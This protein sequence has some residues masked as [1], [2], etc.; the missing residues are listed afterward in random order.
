MMI[1]LCSSLL[2]LN[3]AVVPL[4]RALP[5]MRTAPLEC[6]LDDG[7]LLDVVL[8][9]RN[10][11][12]CRQM[13]QDN[14]KCIFYH[15]YQG[16]TNDRALDGAEDVENQPAQCF[17]YD[18]CNREV[19]PATEDC[20]LTKANAV[21]VE[22]FVRNADECKKSC[23]NNVDCGYFKYFEAGD[24]KQPLFCYHLKKCAPRVIRRAECPLERN[25]Y[26][27]HFLF[28]PTQ[29]DCRQK[30]QDHTECR[31]WYWYPID[32]SPAPLYCYLYRSCEGGADEQTIGM[33]IGGRHPGFYFLDEAETSDLVKGGAVCPKHVESNVTSIGRGG[34]VAEFVE[35]SVLLCG[36]R[37]KQNRVLGNCMAYNPMSNHWDSHS[38]LIDMREE[39]SSVTV[40]GQMYIMGG[41]VNGEMVRTSEKLSGDTWT[42][43]PSLPEGR[44]RFCAVT[45]DDSSIAILGGEVP[46]SDG[47]AISAEM[48]TYNIDNGDWTSQPDMLVRRKDH[49]C[50]LVKIDEEI[51]LLVSGGVDGEDNLLDSV[52]FYNLETQEWQELSPLKKART[53]HG[54]EV[55]GGLVTVLGGV[56]NTEFLSSVEVLDNS[57]DSDAPLGFEWR[58]TAHALTAPRYDFALAVAPV[59]SLSLEDRGM[60]DCSSN[61]EIIES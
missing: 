2:L 28:V 15:F 9:A 13:C 25:N 44:S 39:A 24:A 33:V 17:L 20:P 19:L 56:S 29:T 6:P 14:E 53:E 8:F 22:A 23:S 12:E 57:P 59:S 58:V 47:I 31:F 38:E 10:D 4:I 60:D 36:G 21:N 40:S 51:G 26:I 49:A 34:A 61:L 18:M 50:A 1:Q 55:I 54:M 46:T 48:K 16:A 3:L 32:Y 41:L 7:N 11:E 30:C 35:D 45:L 42:A 27:D 5:M 37:D 43:G 52:E